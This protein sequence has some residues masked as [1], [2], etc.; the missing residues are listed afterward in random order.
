MNLIKSRAKETLNIIKKEGITG[1]EL[2]NLAYDKFDV[3]WDDLHDENVDRKSDSDIYVLLEPALFLFWSE[4]Y[5]NYNIWYDDLDENKMWAVYITD[6]GFDEYIDTFF[7]DE[8]EENDLDNYDELVDNFDDEFFEKTLEYNMESY[9]LGLG[10]YGRG[11][12]FND[13]SALSS[14]GDDHRMIDIDKWFT[15]NIV[16]FDGIGGELTLR[17]NTKLNWDQ[18]HTI[19]EFI[20]D[21]NISKIYYDTYNVNSIVNHGIIDD[22]QEADW[23][24]MRTNKKNRSSSLV[25]QF[26]ENILSF[27]QFIQR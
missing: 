6:K 9:N 17:I 3:D 18:I 2:F 13:G 22:P 24:S 16:T 23:M 20:T 7:E 25:G 27:K 4:V 26:H 19:K 8:L 15:D 1:E 10:M 11:W 12:V 14:S 5:N 21:N